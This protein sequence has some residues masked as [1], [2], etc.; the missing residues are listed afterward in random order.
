MMNESY[1]Q[2]DQQL[3]PAVPVVEQPAAALAPPALV[4][5]SSASMAT[6]NR[7]VDPVV[8]TCNDVISSRFR[9]TQNNG[10]AYY[11][12]LV[13]KYKEQLTPILAKLSARNDTESFTK[14]ILT[15]GAERVVDIVCRDRGGR[16]IKLA[17]SSVKT[18]SEHY[19]ILSRK[20]AVKKVY[21]YFRRSLRITQSSG[22]ESTLKAAP[23][24][25]KVDKTK[26]RSLFQY[27]IQVS[28]SSEVDPY[29][30]DLITAVCN[31]AHS[32]RTRA[33][34]DQIATVARLL[35]TPPVLGIGST[36]DSTTAS[37]CT[38]EADRQTRMRLQ[39]RHRYLAAAR[40]GVS[41][42]DLSQRLVKHWRAGELVLAPPPKLPP[43]VQ[44][45]PVPMAVPPSLPQPEMT[46]TGISGNN[47]AENTSAPVVADPERGQDQNNGMLA[48]NNAAV[49]L[50]LVA[51]VADP[52]NGQDQNHQNNGMLKGNNTA[53]AVAVAD[54]L[55]N[56]DHEG[57]LTGNNTAVAIPDPL[58]GEDH[59]YGMLLENNMRPT[60]VKLNN[61][62]IPSSKAAGSGQWTKSEHAQFLRGLELHGPGNWEKIVELV[63][64]R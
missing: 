46:N 47:S 44:A 51:F 18:G 27:R 37:P 28:V 23:E 54:P 35:E 36:N 40:V 31:H 4:A 58:K 34:K 13:Q 52:G 6:F 57:M 14:R 11:D 48:G 63:P 61:F 12:L 38:P 56:Q 60:D 19:T 10:N 43:V 15:Q 55:K 53:V 21:S 41:P 32:V 17:E 22:K 5:P 20:N 64:T 39:L 25:P 42:V 8:P 24:K 62:A 7:V 2:Q 9:L 45:Q 30:L 1:Q 59:E 16:F 33:V 49:A 26:I 29:M 3:P 50:S